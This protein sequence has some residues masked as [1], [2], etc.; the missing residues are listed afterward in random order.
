[1]TTL[2]ECHICGNSESL[3]THHVDYEKPETKKLC[4]SCHV[5][6]HKE[7]GY[8]DELLPPE[9]QRGHTVADI[10]V[11]KTQIPP[12]D[13]YSIQ[14]K[15]I[16]CGKDCGSCPHGPYYYYY[17]RDGDKVCC[18]YGGKVPSEMLEAVEGRAEQQTL[19]SVGGDAP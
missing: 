14:L 2:D 19:A 4:R 17:K 16:P 5:K 10:E 3:D 9:S 6:V 18:E 1:L 7:D 11:D 13:G 15:Y 8:H 12:R